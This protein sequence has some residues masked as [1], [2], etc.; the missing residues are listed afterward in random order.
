[1]KKFVFLFLTIL[2]PFTQILAAEGDFVY[3]TVTNS[4]GVEKSYELKN[5]KITFSATDMSYNINDS[6]RSVSLASLSNG[7]MRFTEL[8][9]SIAMIVPEE[10]AMVGRG[11]R[12][13]IT[14][15]KASVIQ[16]YSVDGTL[17]LVKKLTTGDTTIDISNLAA[18]IYIAKI[19]NKVI[20]IEKR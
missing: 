5:L 13:D 12:I 17:V 10:T 14:V 15:A 2:A 7:K 8:P 4:E 16:I 6:V 18:G 9:T 11:D 19:N 3:L 20:K 1:M